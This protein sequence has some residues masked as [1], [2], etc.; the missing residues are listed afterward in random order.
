MERDIIRFKKNDIIL[1]L[2]QIESESY[3][4]LGPL[5]FIG[6]A[7][8]FLF[9]SILENDLDGGNGIKGLD[10]FSYVNI[11]GKKI[12]AITLNNYEIIP[13]DKSIFKENKKLKKP[14]QRNLPNGFNPKDLIDEDD[15]STL[16]ESSYK[17]K[18]NP[19]IPENLPG[20]KGRSVGMVG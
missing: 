5:E 19:P 20:M 6:Q 12:Y 15:L 11:N 16:K 8:S 3:E 9:C 2:R 4:T 17:I 10:S 1:I 13:V 14:S 7:N 18:E